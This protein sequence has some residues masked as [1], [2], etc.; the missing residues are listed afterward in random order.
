MET[1]LR[2]FFGRKGSRGEP[3]TFQSNDVRF[4]LQR[5]DD[6]SGLKPHWAA[7]FIFTTEEG[8]REHKKDFEAEG[9]SKWRIVKKTEEVLP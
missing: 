6:K 5:W 3:Q 7:A 4:H 9:K 2:G 8:A 1:K